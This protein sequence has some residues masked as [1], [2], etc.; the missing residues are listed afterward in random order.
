[1]YYVTWTASYNDRP[2]ADIPGVVFPSTS[3]SLLPV[4]PGFSFR[5]HDILI[6]TVLVRECTFHLSII[7]NSPQH[8]KTNNT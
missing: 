5:I 2:A 7:H 6:D 3:Q 4:N 1:M 8:Y